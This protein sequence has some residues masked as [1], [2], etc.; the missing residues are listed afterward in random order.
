MTNIAGVRAVNAEGAVI[1][2]SDALA[3][4]SFR[5]SSAYAEWLAKKEFGI[6]FDNH[7]ESTERHMA[8]VM[9]PIVK[10]SDIAGGLEIHLN[11]TR[12]AHVLSELK[13]YALLGTGGFL[14]L[15]FGAIFF[16]IWRHVRENRK[17]VSALQIARAAMN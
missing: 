1:F 7:K 8:R 16:N 15:V 12:Q 10:G 9:V 5:G 14:L 3:G 17:L 6:S 11:M 2:E 13:N 4:A